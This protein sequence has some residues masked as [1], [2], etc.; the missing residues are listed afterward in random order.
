MENIKVKD[1]ECTYIKFQI[2]KPLKIKR[3]GAVRVDRVGVHDAS[4]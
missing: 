1:Y 2:H 4:R 3:G